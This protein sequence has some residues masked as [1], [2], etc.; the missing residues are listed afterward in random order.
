M[1]IMP[2]RRLER[3]FPPMI[4]KGRLNPGADAEVVVFNPA[5]VIHRATFEEPAQRPAGIRYVL[6]GG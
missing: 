3:R 4:R 5:T 2:A 6:V 1:T